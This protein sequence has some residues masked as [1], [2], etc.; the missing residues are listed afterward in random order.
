[1]SETAVA[2]KER[3][4]TVLPHGGGG[5]P[6]TTAESAKLREVLS[7]GVAQFGYVILA[8]PAVS[9]DATTLQ[10]AASAEQIVLTAQAFKT[11]AHSVQ[12]VMQLLGTSASKLRR[13]VLL[14]EPRPSFF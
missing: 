1:M 2:D 7:L 9:R 10:I 5:A 12:R 4:I 14:T 3:M 11:K 6:L 8:M 13:I